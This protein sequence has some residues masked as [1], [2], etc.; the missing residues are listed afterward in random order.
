MFLPGSLDSTNAKNM[1]GAIPFFVSKQKGETMY[2]KTPAGS[3]E[4]KGANS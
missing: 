4:G 1:A 3:I 2:G